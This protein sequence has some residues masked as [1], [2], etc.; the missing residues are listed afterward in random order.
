MFKNTNKR[1]TFL[2]ITNS[3]FYQINAKDGYIVTVSGCKFDESVNFESSTIEVENSTLNM[4]NS[5]F[6][7]IKASNNVQTILSAVSSRVSLDDVQ[8]S[9]IEAEISLIQITNGSKL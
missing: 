2:N 7:G 5:S 3:K 1:M 4:K 6:I 9:G 8:C